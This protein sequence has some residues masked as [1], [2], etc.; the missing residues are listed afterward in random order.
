MD[1][2]FRRLNIQRAA[3]VAQPAAGGKRPRRIFDW[4]KRRAETSDFLCGLCY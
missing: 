4:R 1:I 2:G 3:V